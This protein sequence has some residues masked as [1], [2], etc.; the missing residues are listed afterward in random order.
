M[1]EMRFSMLSEEF[2][3][4]IYH[5]HRIKVCKELSYRI[6]GER[7]TGANA[8]TIAES[9]PAGGNQTQEEGGMLD[10]LLD[11]LEDLFGGG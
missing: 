9:A 2:I 1:A 10:P 3:P 4:F 6:S 11:P 8:T 7:A 5:C